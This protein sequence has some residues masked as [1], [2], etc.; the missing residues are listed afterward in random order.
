M[1]ILKGRP[2]DKEIWKYLLR[3]E[4]GN[5]TE[6]WAGKIG[7]NV[8]LEDGYD[9][10]YITTIGGNKGITIAHTGRKT[11]RIFKYVVPDKDR[12][13]KLLYPYTDKDKLKF[14]KWQDKQ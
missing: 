12:A 11:R 1:T 9:F 8:E 13:P 3:K 5:S 4:V 14:K 10:V 7:C 6:S 2:T